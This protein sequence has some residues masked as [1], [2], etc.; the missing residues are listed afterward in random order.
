MANYTIS[1]SN[2][3]LW[4]KQTIEKLNNFDK[5]YKGS[6]DKKILS[7]C[8]V[9]NQYEY[10]FTLSSCSGRISLLK[11]NDNKKH[12]NIW[13]YVTHELTNFKIINNKL[14]SYKENVDLE[15]RQEAPIIHIMVKNLELAHKL[16]HIGKISGFNQV[17]IISIKNK[18]VVELI[19]DYNIIFPISKNSLKKLDN[20]NPFLEN[21]IIKANNNLEKGWINIK[22]L[23]E[24]IK[25]NFN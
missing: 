23:E 22:R 11:R 3:K 13:Y 14:E 7:L 21:I 25:K 5:S 16:L 20:L 4:K 19:C 2:F 9:I 15:F 24:N 10:F 12:E 18:I 6:I 8:N 17:G 1:D